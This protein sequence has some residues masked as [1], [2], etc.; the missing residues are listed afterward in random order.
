MLILQN[1]AAL[2]PA[3]LLEDGDQM[4]EIMEF[5]SVATGVQIKTLNAI[6]KKNELGP[7]EQFNRGYQMPVNKV[8]FRFGEIRKANEGGV[9]DCISVSNHGDA[10]GQSRYGFD[11]YQKMPA[12]PIIDSNRL[13]DER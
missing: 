1:E 2:S 10:I 11:M 5:Q 8:S 4:R 9:S 12:N 7:G 13:V 6:K 3:V